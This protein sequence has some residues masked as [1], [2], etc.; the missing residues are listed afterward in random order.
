MKIEQISVDAL[1]PRPN[2]P[3]T[4]SPKQ[5]QQIADSIECFGFTN[6]IL[7]DNSNTII[8]GHGRWAAARKLNLEKVPVVRLTDMSEDEIRA[9][10]IADNKLAENAGW[11]ADLLRVELG[12]LMALDLDFSIEITGFETPEIDILMDVSEP[13]AAPEI[14]E[15][16]SSE[17]PVSQ[18]GDLWLLGG[19]RL[20]CGDALSDVSY[21]ALMAGETAA[22]VFTDPPYN[23]KIGEILNK[24]GTKHREFAMASGEMD[25]DSYEAFLETALSKMAP[26]CSPG[27]IA[28][29]CMDWR[30]IRELA[31]VG[32]CLFEDLKNI[33]VWDKG[34]GG[35][36]SLYRSQHELVFVFKVS[37]GKHV[38]N[39]QLGRHGRNRTNV[40]RYPGVQSRRE[41]LQLH[42]TVKPISMVADALRDVTLRGDVVL[43]PFLGSGTT[44]LAA[45]RT[46]RTC[47]GIELDP[48]YVDLVIERFERETGV[49]AIHAAS[50]KTFAQ[51]ASARPS[52]AA[53]TS[54]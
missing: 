51:V 23:L 26:R 16:P 47:Y 44:L 30:H 41:D 3:R 2:N 11:D 17:P 43:D 4:H 48:A 24:G 37:A 14:A 19:H 34:V 7:A 9:Y 29:I 15:E 50:G 22:A 21:Q 40:W 32:H 12:E 53:D 1:R 46:G 42:P 33:S 20:Y 38:N 31:T 27:A 28:F 35:M 54:P 49:E 45:E 5:I 52:S 18:Q 6:P 39:I 36:G 13:S 8:A 25:A 10:V